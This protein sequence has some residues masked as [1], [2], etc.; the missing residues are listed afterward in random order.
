MTRPG[1]ADGWWQEWGALCLAAALALPLFTPRVYGSDEIKY[2][3]T[4]RSL[5]FDHDLHYANDYAHFVSRDPVGHAGLRPYAEEPTPTGY[6]LNDGP[7]GSAVLWSPFFVVADVGVQV[8]RGL[9]A[10]VPRDGFSRPYTTAVCVGSLVWGT[11]GLLLIYRL[12]R[13]YASRS[14]ATWAVLAI[15]FASPVVFYLYITPAMAHA[16]SLF[17]VALFLTVWQATRERRTTTGWALLGAT[18]GLMVLVR[19]LNWLF[20]LVVAV[21]ELRAIG[22]RTQAAQPSGGARTTALMAAAEAQ[23]LR[24]RA[25]GYVAFAVVLAIVVSPQFYVYKIL[26]GTF[27]ATPFVVQKFSLVPRYAF[28]VLFSGFHGLFSWHPVTLLGVV[29]LAA[30]WRRAPAVA[31]ALALVF[32]VQ[33][34]VIGSYSTWWGGA[35]F[36]A[37]R[38]VNCSAIFAAGLAAALDGLRPRASRLARALLVFLVLWNAG[39]AVQ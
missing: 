31:C 23:E 2:F 33:V 6:R 38:F 16:N 1:R 9:G 27:A 36:G 8:A 29:G 28:D 26:N 24:R 18:A 35:S 32:V 30:L 13:R 37:R 21:D 20:L 34:L 19:E 4:L 12:C 15:W 14:P 39:L 17:A 25:G 22:V 10:D 5:Y 7:I 3:V 11:V